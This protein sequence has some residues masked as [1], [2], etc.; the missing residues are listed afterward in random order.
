MGDIDIMG[1]GYTKNTATHRNVPI[2]TNP[3]LRGGIVSIYYVGCLWGALFGGW[4]GD[5]IG[6]I[7]TIAPKCA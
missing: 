5:K 1:F 7:K 3:T 2:I 6:G 4:I